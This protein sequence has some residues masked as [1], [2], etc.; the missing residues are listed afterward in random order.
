MWHLY[1]NCVLPTLNK[2]LVLTIVLCFLQFKVCKIQYQ[3]FV[4]KVL[5][6][7]KKRSI[8]G[9][10]QLIMLLSTHHLCMNKE[11]NSLQIMGTPIFLYYFFTS[12][13]VW[14]LMSLSTIFQLY[15]GGQFY[16]WRKPEY[17]EKTTDLT[18]V[19]DTNFIT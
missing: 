17:L 1:Q 4:L 5:Y 2:W 14:C 3:S 19:T 12:M 16:W 9:N 10:P 13:K 15:R 11:R 6:L 7:T 18:E 8:V